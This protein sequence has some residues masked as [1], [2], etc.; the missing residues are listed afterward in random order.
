MAQVSSSLRFQPA[1]DDQSL[2]ISNI[3]I[4]IEHSLEL[5]DEEAQAQREAKLAKE[6][7]F[8]NRIQ[9][10]TEE[11][12][13]TRQSNSE[14]IQKN[15]EVTSMYQQFSGRLDALTQQLGQPRVE[16]V[17]THADE[18]VALKLERDQLR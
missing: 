5:F 12:A 9:T 17:C 10:L 8:Y 16:A 7:E 18:I 3:E 11:L 14:L 4:H 15:F 2:N 1:A 13:A 6:Q